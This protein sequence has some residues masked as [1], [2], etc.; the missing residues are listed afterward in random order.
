VDNLTRIYSNLHTR[1]TNWHFTR[2][3]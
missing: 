2:P 1:H 3:E